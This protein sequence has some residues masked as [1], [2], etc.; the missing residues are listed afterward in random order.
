[1]LKDRESF[2]I[3]LADTET[4]LIVIVQNISLRKHIKYN[5]VKLKG[6]T[7]YSYV[8]YT[9]PQDKQYVFDMAR[10]KKLKI[11]W[12]D[13]DFFGIIDFKNSTKGDIVSYLSNEDLGEGTLEGACYGIY[14]AFDDSLVSKIVT[15]YKGHGESE[16][17]PRFGKYY[18]KEISASVGY[19]VSDEKYYFTSDINSINYNTTIKE[20]VIKK[21]IIFFK[22]KDSGKTGLMYPEENVEF[23]IVNSKGEEV[24]RGK[25][26]D[27]GKI[28]VSLP[29]GK[30]IIK[31]LS[32]EGGYEF[33]DDYEFEVRDSVPLNKVFVDKKIEAKLK[34]I[35]VDSE[36]GNVIKGSAKFKIW[37]V[38]D[39]LYVCYK[40]S[41]GKSDICEFETDSDGE[42]ITPISLSSGK[43]I[44][45]EISSPYGY[46]I[47]KE[48]YEFKNMLTVAQLIITSALQR[49]ESRGA[50]YREDYPMTK[51]IA[52]H[53]CIIKEQGE[54]SFVR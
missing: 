36:T 21:N 45:K 27:D 1:M 40:A 10:N 2:A 42:F 6:D 54:L 50:H 25:T 5:R 22:M 53:N 8:L 30:Y 48:E 13:N 31:Q 11:V 29:Y 41:N 34:V 12:K 52:E 39:N 4:D 35:K 51:E 28:S 47:S 9:E 38:D 15:D 26:D 7:D 14:N 18:L 43:Y 16:P 23:S 49:K 19:E 32:G 24:Y 33:I 20:N 44:L 17:L 46:V 3:L 37:S